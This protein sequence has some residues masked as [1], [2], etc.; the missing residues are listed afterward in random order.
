LAGRFIPRPVEVE[1][2]DGSLREGRLVGL[3]ERSMAPLVV[4]EPAQEIKTLRLSLD[5]GP[6]EVPTGE[7]RRIILRPVERLVIRTDSSVGTLDLGSGP[8]KLPEPPGWYLPETA[9]AT[10][11]PAVAQWPYYGWRYIPEAVWIWA[12]SPRRHREDETVLFRHEFNLP[13]T[14]TLVCARL[15][16]SADDHIEAF[17]INGRSVRVPTE[18]LVGKVSSWDVTYMLRP[19]RNVVAARVTNDRSSGQLN[20][21]G[22]CYR[23]VCHLVPEQGS[24][25]SAPEPP[26]V[27]LLLAN[28]DR[29]SG[30]LLAAT[31]KRWAVRRGKET[32][33][34]DPD[35]I[36]LALVNY[37][38]SSAKTVVPVSPLRK[39]EGAPILNKILRKGR[40]L[41][42]PVALTAGRW[43]SWNLDLAPNAR[44]EGIL[45]RTGE[46][47][48]GRIEGLH[49]NRV[50]IKPRYGEVFGV[51]I[52]RVALIQPNRPDPEMR[53]L[54]RP[55]DFPCIIRVRLRNND[56][57]TG[58]LES[59]TPSSITFTPHFSEP[60]RLDLDEVLSID[61]VM[62][63]VA[64]YRG[65]LSRAWPDWLPRQVAAIGEASRSGSRQD[66]RAIE[67]IQRTLLYLGIDLE[68]LDAY[69]TV[70]PGRLTPEHY[71]VLINLDQ[72]ERFYYSVKKP[73]DGYEAIKRYVAEGGTLVH[74]ARGIPF[75]RAVVAGR[76][77]WVT[78][79]PP[80]DLNAELMMDIVA[81]DRRSATIRPFQLPP[82]RGQKMTFVLNRLSPF[83]EGLPPAVEVPMAADAR[84]R[85]IAADAV[86]SPA[87]FFPIYR[88]VDA[89]GRQYGV[90][91]AVIDYGEKDGRH[92]YGVY[93][94]HLLYEASYE[95]SPMI[96]YL[97]PKVLQIALGA[98][99]VS[100]ANLASTPEP[101]TP[102]SA[103]ALLEP[104]GSK[105]AVPP[106]LPRQGPIHEESI[107]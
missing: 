89:K 60:V 87:R 88:L 102:A 97:L 11:E 9:I 46:W 42:P 33:E 65:L 104:S 85:P 106:A 58:A 49:E 30:D 56:R 57:I 26:G 84:F 18:S 69:M 68:W 72:N 3:S 93:V 96:E 31:P 40:R 1:L 16:L 73:G 38:P 77:R 99:D 70:E 34:I 2:I 79:R 86:T 14:A 66:N 101:G 32:I 94:S 83:A 76:S 78:R 52:S 20:Y 15:D 64:H 100:F 17:F 91:M 27:R 39:I 35:W 29:I 44:R 28:G 81:P 53:F 13:T 71:P 103:R 8:T 41:G 59:L 63:V 107:P 82:N 105:R 7:I 10:W 23:I 98:S 67:T 24:S 45:A 48:E 54:F 5:G 6:I 21:A 75:A 36:N 50:L 74:F 22:F 51:P 19:G 43:V 55:S 61:F 4:G 47:I 95:E 90:A 37:S 92:H 62:N 12:K 80:R 25:P